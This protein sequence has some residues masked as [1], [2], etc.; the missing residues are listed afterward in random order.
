MELDAGAA[1]KY[2]VS[3]LTNDLPRNTL[4]GFASVL[5]PALCDISIC[6][7]HAFLANE[8]ERALNCLPAAHRI[9]EVDWE[10]A[11]LPFR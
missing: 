11:V 1:E 5:T 3:T 4:I 2:V 9:T 10:N 7:S 6:A 8:S